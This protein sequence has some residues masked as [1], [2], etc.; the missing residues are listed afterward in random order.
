M[1][2]VA[3][4]FV[5]RLLTEQQ[6]QGRVELCSPLKEKF[7]NDPNFFPKVITGNESWC[8]RYDPETK[9]QSS[10]WKTPASPRPKKAR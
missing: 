1:R 3:A 4:K 10:Q 6:K 8:Y 2:R 7:Q 5:S 9:Q